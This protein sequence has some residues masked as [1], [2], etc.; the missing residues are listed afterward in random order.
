MEELQREEDY[1][2]FFERKERWEAKLDPKLFVRDKETQKA[3]EIP[4]DEDYVIPGVKQ[5][6]KVAKKIETVK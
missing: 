1:M 2:F 6:Q 4:K 5:R 3:P